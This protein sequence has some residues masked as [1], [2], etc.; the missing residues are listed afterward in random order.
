MPA[1]ELP[2]GLFDAA[3]ETLGTKVLGSKT[4]DHSL[5]FAYMVALPMQKSFVAFKVRLL[6]SSHALAKNQCQLSHSLLSLTLSFISEWVINGWQQLP[7]LGSVR[8][9]WNELRAAVEAELFLGGLQE[10]QEER[11]LV[12]PPLPLG[13]ASSSPFL[14]PFFSLF[15]KQ[16]NKYPQES[17]LMSPPSGTATMAIISELWS[18]LC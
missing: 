9:N 14:L 12:A 13:F 18:L 8:R 1:S 17:T 6:P 4:I 16:T 11:S 7:P 5:A 10:A 2:V 3:L 15:D